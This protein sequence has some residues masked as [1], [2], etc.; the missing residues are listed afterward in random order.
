MPT[1]LNKRDKVWRAVK[2][3]KHKFGSSSL[4]GF[5]L[6]STAQPVSETASAVGAASTSADPFGAENAG[7][8]TAGLLEIPD[9][10]DPLKRRLFRMKRPFNPFRKFAQLIRVAFP[11]QSEIDAERKKEMAERKKL[12]ALLKSEAAVAVQRFHGVFKRMNLTEKPMANGKGNTGRVWFDMIEYNPNS[13]YL[14]IGSFPHNTDVLQFTD[15]GVA[16]NLS[17]AV[18][19]HVYSSFHPTRGLTYR[20]DRNSTAGLPDLVTFQE[21]IKVMSASLPPL[22][23]PVGRIANGRQEY[24][25]IDDGPHMLIGGETKGGKSN[26]LNVI[27]G[28]IMFRTTPR[29]V[30]FMMVDLKGNGIELSFWEGTPHLLTLA[31][32]G[33]KAPD[34]YPKNGIAAF[35]DQALALLEYAADLADERMLAYTKAG[36]KNIDQWNKSHK[37]KRHYHLVICIDE[38]TMVTDFTPKKSQT[39]LKRLAA[40]ARAA[41]IH[42]VTALQTA[43]R[44]TFTQ[45]MKT[46]FPMRIAFAFQDVTGSALMVGDSSAINLEPAGRAVFKHGTRKFMIQ[47]PFISNGDIETITKKAKG[48]IKGDEVITFSTAM[49]TEQDILQWALVENDGELTRDQAFK[50]F[51]GK[52]EK[53]ALSRMLKSMDGK[54]FSVGEHEYIVTPGY[55]TRS[56][57]VERF[58]ADNPSPVS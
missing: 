31:D 33:D 26:M 11:K 37:L 36:A 55:G 6:T 57:R 4:K 46:N 50:H 54:R 21:C 47:T 43:D 29:D 3:V 1:N 48:E 23:F 28:S 22:S 53:D 20:I 8:L 7:K 12:E 15:S 24:A 27:I 19:R 17:E 13:I 44:T 45:N 56:R 9:N 42:V 5:T 40:I 34:K 51:R 52:I 25:N 49:V 30:R 38:W 32:I 10:D 18:R 39:L 16:T 2:E 35:P 58:N 41:G 14:H